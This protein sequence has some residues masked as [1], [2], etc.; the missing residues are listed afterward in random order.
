MGTTEEEIV[1]EVNYKHE[2]KVTKN[3]PYL[4]SGK[5]PIS[6][7]II[8]VNEEGV[9][10]EWRS[11]K[12]YPMQGKCGLCRCGESEKRPFCDGTHAK[13]G[14]DGTE[15]A[16]S[17]PYLKL[18]KIIQGPTLKLTDVE[19][20]CASARF[21]HRAGEIWNL[22][23]KSDRLEAKRAAIEEAGDCPSGR[24]V[25]W[26]KKTGETIEPKL[27]KSIGLIEDPQME[28]SGPIWVRGG[29]PIR[30]ADGKIYEIRNRVTLCRCGK[31]SIKP[32]CD[33]SHFP[34]HR[35]E[36]MMSPK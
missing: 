34:Q 32:F 27:E 14:F 17:E 11:G 15:V 20:L 36:E 16:S 30:S 21:C 13:I 7:Q 35:Y 8:I 10:V 23:P 2:I 28:C 22:I 4:V 24:L 26:N 3:G 1:D 6:E 9:P 18:A 31:S 19:D 25:I 12:E 29:I 33:S 5:L